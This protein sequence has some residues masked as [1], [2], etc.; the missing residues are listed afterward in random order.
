MPLATMFFDGTKFVL[1]IF[2]EDHPVT[3]S[4]KLFSTLTSGFRETENFF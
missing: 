3:I 4:A 1:A 2:V